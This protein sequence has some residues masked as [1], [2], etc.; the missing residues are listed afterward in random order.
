M[1]GA[2]DLC[3][4][5]LPGR[6]LI[7]V[8]GADAATLLQG[9]ISNDIA[10]LTSDRALYAAL[11]TPQGKYLFDFLLYR[12]G[13]A[14]LLDSEG[15]RVEELAR[16]LLMYR[17]RAR[18]EI[19]PVEGA[20]GVAAL[21]DPGGRPLGE[22]AADLARLRRE[23][24][25]ITVPD[26]R[27]SALG[28]RIVGPAGALAA[29]LAGLPVAPFDSYDRLRLREAV[30]DGSRDLV[31][32]KSTL[33]E[34]NFEELGGVAFD[35]GCFVGQEL[36][37]RTKYRGL[38][39]KRLVPVRLEGGTPEPGT[40]ILA[41]EREAGELRSVSGD[42]GL[43]LLRLEHLRPTSPLRAGPVGVTPL[44]P[45]WMPDPEPG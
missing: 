33:L 35:K 42:L 26:P 29:A 27:S 11:L 16:R 5:E 45:P 3:V 15:G 4:T 9:L 25:L 17:L 21:Y 38:V 34:S 19:E 20:W 2:A 44:P 24:G 18:A 6:G 22:D 12:S 1:A 43:A 31:V 39:K 10:K 14:V 32:Q 36:T 41:G 8:S 7:R 13:E 40:P 23:T 37:A 28:W 30:P